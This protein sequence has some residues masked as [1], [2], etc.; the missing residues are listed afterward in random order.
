MNYWDDA[1]AAEQNMTFEVKALV[2]QRKF[3]VLMVIA[4]VLTLLTYPFPIS[5]YTQSAQTSQVESFFLPIGLTIIAILISAIALININRAF[6]EFLRKTN[7]SLHL[8]GVPRC[9]SLVT[10][11]QYLQALCF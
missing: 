2:E 3:S 7:R 4:F 11:L 5:P 10:L 1:M 6:K 9:Y 8:S